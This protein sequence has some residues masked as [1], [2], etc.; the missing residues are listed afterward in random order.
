MKNEKQLVFPDFHKVEYDNPVTALSSSNVLWP[1][2]NCHDDSTAHESYFAE[3]L[4]ISSKAEYLTFRASI[5]AWL[6]AVAKIQKHH[7]QQMHQPGGCPTSQSILNTNAFYI[8]YMIEMRRASKA[9]SIR[10]MN[11][12][13]TAA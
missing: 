1:W 6:R 11:A 3:K 12:S 2:F 4:G 9:W 8:T 5:K 7:K 10:K 13:R